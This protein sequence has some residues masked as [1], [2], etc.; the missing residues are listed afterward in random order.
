MM[1]SK[2]GK[3]LSFAFQNMLKEFQPNVPQDQQQA[4]ENDM[5][6]KI[7]KVLG[8]NWATL[9]ITGPRMMVLVLI[10]NYVLLPYGITPAN[11]ADKAIE[12]GR[13]YEVDRKFADLMEQAKSTAE[14]TGHFTSETVR[15]LTKYS[16]EKGKQIGDSLTEILGPAIEN[17]KEA[18]DNGIE[19]GKGFFATGLARGKELFSRT[20][21]DAE[22]SDDSEDKQD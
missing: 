1:S 16:E 19:K 2:K 5:E 21:K 22:Y 12:K 7:K 8:S 4:V 15:E 18:I 3:L 13:E 9:P 10:M 20:R 14:T 17:A 11:I 6:G